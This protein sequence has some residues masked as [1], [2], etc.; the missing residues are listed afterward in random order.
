MAN[1]KNTF[2]IKRSN[3]SG[4]VPSPG[5]LQLGEL[6]INTANVILYASGT[7]TN[8]ILPIGWDR[9]ARTGDT[10]TGNFNFI[11]DMTISGSS[12]PSGYALSVTGDT[13]FVGDVYVSGDLSY[14]GSVLVTGSTII[15]NGLTANTIYTD[16]I[17]LNTA[18]TGPTTQGRL[19]WDSGTGTLNIGVGDVGGT[20]I[21]LQVGQEEL[22]RV[23]NSEATTLQKGEIVYVFGSQGNRPSVKRAIATS[24]GYSVTTLGMVTSNITSGSEGYVTTFGIISNLNTNGLTGGTAIWLSPTVAGAYTTL[25]PQAPYHT[26]LIGYVVRVD[27]TVGSVF[28]N[29]SNGWEIDELHDVR[30]NGKTQGDLISYSAYNGSNVWV[31][32]KTLN[33][34]YTITGDTTVGGQMKASSVSATTYYN[35]PIDVRVTG[36]TYDNNTFTFT[37]NTGG[38]FN[39]LFNS[40]TGLTSTG[41]ILSSVLSATTISATTY[42]NLPADLWTQ[43]GT[44]IY[45]NTGNVGIGTT[46][47][48]RKFEVVDGTS[49]AYF[50]L[51]GTSGPAAVVVTTDLTK[52]TRFIASDGTNSINVGMRTSGETANPGFGGQNDA[53]IYVNT[54]ANGLNI[55]NAQSTGN[56]DYI[57]LYAG[58]IANQGT[59]HLHVQGSG[60]TK[61]FIGINT[62]NPIAR[63]HVSGDTLISGGLTATTI[64]ATTYFNLPTDIR[65][66]GGTYSNNTFT[67]TNNTGG[68][69]NVAFNTVT[70]L[71]VNGNLTVTGNTY[72]QAISGTSATLSGSGQSI[73]TVIGSGNS[74]S[75]PI[76]SIQ[77]SSGELFSV[78]DSLTGSLFSVNDI[79]GLPVVEVFSDNTMLVGSY[80]AP[81]LNTTVKTILTAGTNT[82]YSIP[83]SAY[84]GS[85]IDYTV[86]STG[87]T[88]ARAGTIMS[89]WSGTTA[90]YT[91]VSTNDIGTTAGITFSVSVVGSNAV[92]SSS[93]TTAGWTLKT[94]IRSI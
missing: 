5:D 34:S 17:D 92:I 41:T 66:T 55:I 28:V 68:T 62:E 78:T 63:L 27:A 67:Y 88:G 44:S 59:S 9:V 64:S 94:I 4:K 40:V 76:F 39:V 84:T 22:V 37:N 30:I 11:G 33:G 81:A 45:Y 83:T 13:N 86:I 3:I 29:I 1:R 57:R 23:F 20:L 72:L 48:S 71:T 89:I 12:L 6:A 14:S 7:T 24:D 8:S 65:V 2:L 87:A 79:S 25:K 46:N 10:V 75:S 38:T 52:L 32:T 51:T 36:S 61:G 85:F 49:L 74:T 15:Q 16:Y 18:Y 43:N 70:G 19:S 60:S 80:Q 47:P 90:Q 54:T 91:D 53:F 56:S 73:L 26:V 42:Y 50:N 69:F 58:L 77:G 82:I 31:N 35:L 21:D 93:A